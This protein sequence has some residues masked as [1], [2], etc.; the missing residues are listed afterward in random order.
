MISNPRI[1]I[2]LFFLLCVVFLTVG[3]GYGPLMTSDGDRDY[4]LSKFL[5]SKNFDL[6]EFFR[7]NQAIKDFH[8]MTQ[9]EINYILYYFILSVI[10]LLS[11][12]HPEYIQI[13]F[14]CAMSSYILLYLFNTVSKSRIGY[15]CGFLMLVQFMTCWEYIQWFSMTQPDSIFISISALLLAF[16]IKLLDD[17]VRSNAKKYILLILFTS[18]FSIFFRPIG[19]VFIW[20]FFSISIVYLLWWRG[21]SLRG[22]FLFMIGLFAAALV[23]GVVLVHDPGLLPWEGVT[24]SLA[25]YHDKISQGHVVWVRPETYVDG[26]GDLLVFFKVSILRLGYFFWFMADDFSFGH[27]MLNLAFFPVLY[28][29]VAIGLWSAYS[30]TR[31][32]ASQVIGWIALMA[33]TCVLCF[34]VFHGVT[35]LDYNWRYRAPVYPALF[36][37]SAIGFQ[38]IVKALIRNGLPM[39]FFVHSLLKGAN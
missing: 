28:A 3:L 35:L 1:S 24:R 32:D 33:S 7:T 10:L 27:T 2:S 30:A 29:T 9:P 23:I 12:E 19:V 20:W 25:L 34:A 15:F 37:L 39:P 14:N 26:G 4:E 31:A 38:T 5:I 6:S 21:I 22:T 8:E 17:S 36:L 13:L 11:P 18:I 16:S